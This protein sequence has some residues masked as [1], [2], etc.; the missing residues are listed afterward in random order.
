[1]SKLPKISIVTPSYNQAQFLEETILSILNQNY[2]NLE[3]II[4]D[5]GSADGSVDIIRKY[6][7]YLFY[8]VSEKDRGQSH[9]LNKGFARS[10]GEIMAYLNSDDMYCPWTFKTV[11]SIFAE[12]PEVKWLTSLRPIVWNA[13]GEPIVNDQKHGFARRAFY[14][15]RTLGCSKKHIGWIM[16]EATF[17]HRTL[18]EK[19]GGCISEELEYAMDFELWARFYEHAELVGLTVPLGG[20]RLHGNQKSADLEKYYA[21]A[22]S[23]LNQYNINK[24]VLKN[25][26]N[27]QWVIDYNWHEKKRV[28]KK[29]REYYPW[30]YKITWAL[31]VIK[32]LLK[33]R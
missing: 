6:E 32:R 5:G 19:T 21:E 17:W 11:A 8:W 26:G 23:V 20:F 27:E 30:S 12:F 16:Q 14:S 28:L 25:K 31:G 7:K 22:R 2:P 1:M 4:I 33:I 18:W 24:N 15:G 3:Y 10:T 9:A 13:S 29:W